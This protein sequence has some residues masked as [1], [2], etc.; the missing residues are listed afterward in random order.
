MWKPLLD[1][2]F[3]SI[4]ESSQNYIRETVQEGYTKADWFEFHRYHIPRYD[5]IV[6]LIAGLFIYWTLSRINVQLSHIFSFIITIGILYIFARTN[7]INYSNDMVSY[8]RKLRFLN[9]IMFTDHPQDWSSIAGALA[10]SKSS[11]ES[12]IP[13]N[14]TYMYLYP[15]AVDFFYDQRSWVFIHYGGYQKSLMNMNSAIEQWWSLKQE[16][17]RRVQQAVYSWFLTACTNCY[18]GYAEIYEGLTLTK[19]FQDKY[20][21]GLKS[22]GEILQGLREDAIS[23]LSE[24]FMKGEGVDTHWFVVENNRFPLPD[25][26]ELPDAAPWQGYI[27]TQ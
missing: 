14:K 22:L 19:D 6:L 1:R 17:N 27:P 9:A 4:N 26:R 10:R 24:E 15:I 3:R 12:P 5:W 23:Y 20:R 2:W 21:E 18:N 25:D 7:M 8:D 16:K 11:F 13:S